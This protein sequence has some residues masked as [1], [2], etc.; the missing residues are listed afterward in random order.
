MRVMSESQSAKR[1]RNIPSY[2]TWRAADQPAPSR[3]APAQCVKPAFTLLFQSDGS[4]TPRGAPPQSDP[5]PSLIL[6]ADHDP[7][8]G[9][10]LEAMVRRFGYQSE[11]V[12]T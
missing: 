12:D 4:R 11:S 5:M 9:R 1:A 2:W 8:Q 7:V 6:I 10:L 3:P